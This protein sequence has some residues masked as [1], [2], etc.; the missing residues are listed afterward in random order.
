VQT[1]DPQSPGPSVS[2]VQTKKTPE[3][4]EGHWM[5]LNQQLKEISEW[6]TTLISCTAQV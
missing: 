1:P 5:P 3:N 6:N 2:M 4:V